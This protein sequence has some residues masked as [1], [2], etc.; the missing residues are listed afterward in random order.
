MKEEVEKISFKEFLLMGVTIFIGI[1]V[2]IKI[3]PIFLFQYPSSDLIDE[4]VHMHII[5]FEDYVK[6]ITVSILALTALNIS[7]V[8][9]GIDKQGKRIEKK[10]KESIMAKS[11]GD[12]S[13]SDVE[14]ELEDAFYKIYEGYNKRDISIIKDYV[15]CNIYD[16]YSEKIN[17][18]IE[19]DI[20][21]VRDRIRL[22]QSRPVGV[23]S[24]TE[25]IKDF[26]WF[27]IEATMQDYRINEN[28]QK[29]I[30]DKKDK[31]IIQQYWKMILKD[32]KWV[33]DKTLKKDEIEEKEFY[34]K[35]NME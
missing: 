29:I 32:G 30:G 14:G 9:Y 19:D 18:L 20:I 22:L 1:L 16:Y 12:W 34:K 4:N 26:L 10:Y 7:L 23:F 13:Y 2:I 31:I 21:N 33:L 28:T 27:Y 35:Y 25:E 8:L 5:T 17:K 3:K 24:Y 11:N 6:E 15:S